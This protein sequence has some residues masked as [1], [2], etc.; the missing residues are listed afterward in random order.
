MLEAVGPQLSFSC[1]HFLS[2][3]DTYCYKMEASSVSSFP[4][5]T[6]PPRNTLPGSGNSNYLTYDKKGILSLLSLYSS[7]LT[8]IGFL[9]QETHM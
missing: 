9:S 4:R 6:G 1:E 5:H 7:P 3:R 8:W 2:K